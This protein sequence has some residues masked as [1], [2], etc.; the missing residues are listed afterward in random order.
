MQHPD[1]GLIHTWLDG[2]LSADEAAKLGDHVAGCAQC[3]AV[4]AEARGLIAASSRIVSSLDIIP[5]G[6]IPVAPVA[7][8][9]RWSWYATTQFR[10]AAALL[11]VAGASMLLTRRDRPSSVESLSSRIQ[12]VAAKPEDA[13]V[14]ADAAIPLYPP[15]SEARKIAALPP[16]ASMSEVSP[17]RAS[18]P[19]KSPVAEVA[20]SAP[21]MQT[22]AADQAATGVAVEASKPEISVVRSDSSA[23]TR[24]TV[25][26]VNAG[27]QVVLTETIAA[28]FSRAANQAS[29]ANGDA[30]KAAVTRTITWVDAPTGRIY[31]LSGPLLVDQLEAVK[32]LVV[33]LKK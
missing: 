3:A 1:E 12:S 4:V 9:A 22:V 13:P 16:V 6:V 30:V 23:T 11:V 26:Q 19:R 28:N 10:A 31:T 24:R 21:A 20:Q 18:E 7:Q 27:V 25:F 2:E 15:K 5:A 14:A 29:A 32:E 33:K 8:P 17:R